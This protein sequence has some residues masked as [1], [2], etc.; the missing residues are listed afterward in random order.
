MASTTHHDARIVLGEI[1]QTLPWQQAEIPWRDDS[2]ATQLMIEK[3]DAGNDVPLWRTHGAADPFAGVGADW[4]HGSLLAFPPTTGEHGLGYGQ[5]T[6][7]SGIS[8]LTKFSNSMGNTRPFGSD[9]SMEWLAH[10]DGS[11]NQR[12]NALN[13]VKCLQE[14]ISEIQSGKLSINETIDAVYE[15]PLTSQTATVEQRFIARHT[16]TGGYQVFP[17][18]QDEQWEKILNKITELDSHSRASPRNFGLMPPAARRGEK[19][20]AVETI[21]AKVEALNKGTP[22]SWLSPEDSDHKIKKAAES[23]RGARLEAASDYMMDIAAGAMIEIRPERIT[24]P[25]HD[26]PDLWDKVFDSTNEKSASALLD[27]ISDW[28]YVYPADIRM[29]ISEALQDKVI[30]S[31][32]THSAT[33]LKETV[34]SL[35]AANDFITMQNV[36]KRELNDDS[37]R[38]AG[39]IL[40][41]TKKHFVQD[42]GRDTCVIHSKTAVGSSIELQQGLSMKV[43]YRDGKMM[44]E[45]RDNKQH[46]RSFALSR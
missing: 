7:P 24:V 10:D 34:A 13:N 45:S 25:L 4:S 30:G 6:L 17:I 16:P 33:Q 12:V 46:D 37:G 38:Y 27:S 21:F 22:L 18:P 2:S 11:A 15:T 5:G 28:G 44:V 1:L 20:A 40:L 8:F 36:E 26:I 14:I 43:Q 29:A 32:L 39:V 9:F 23:I 35:S 3:L 19:C 41:E 42:L 31:N